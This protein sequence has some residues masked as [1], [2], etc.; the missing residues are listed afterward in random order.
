MLLSSKG[1]LFKSCCQDVLPVKD[2][3]I[4]ELD[5][6]PQTQVRDRNCPATIQIKK[7]ARALTFSAPPT[8]GT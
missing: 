5:S 6:Y 4:Y 1:Y 7:Y 8:G 3:D 2:R